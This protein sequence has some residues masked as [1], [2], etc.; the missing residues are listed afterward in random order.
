MFSLRNSKDNLEDK[1]KEETQGES[2]DC[3]NEPP[4]KKKRKMKTCKKG[5]I[6][7]FREKAPEDL[8]VAFPVYIQRGK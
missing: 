2:K 6:S 7:L 3:E 1:I 8:F 4:V 5:Y